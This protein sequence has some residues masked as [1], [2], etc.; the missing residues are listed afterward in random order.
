MYLP[1]QALKGAVKAVRSTK[2]RRIAGSSRNR[3]P[4]WSDA[5]T[6]F[7]LE[8]WRDSFPIS[9]RRN[10]AAWDSIV[11]KLNGVLKEHGISTFHTGAQCKAQMKYLQDEYKRVKDHNS[12]SGNNRETFDYFDEI[13]PVL[14]CKPNIAPKRV[15]ECGFS[16]DASSSSV[17]T[18]DS[19]DPPQSSGQGDQ[20]SDVELEKD[21]E[22]NLQGNSQPSKKANKG[23][24]PVTTKKRK[25]LPSETS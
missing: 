6:R 25:A 22:K 8:L 3:C 1:Q 23:K 13:D 15:F 20:S 19:A 21:F 24:T 17:E 14:C 12:R 11:K 5:E 7:L 9:E 10:G 4:N 18:G 16:E 2:C